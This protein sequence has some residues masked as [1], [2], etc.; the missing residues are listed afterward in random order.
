MT[1]LCIYT[2]MHIKIVIKGKVAIVGEWGDM[3]G[4]R[5]TREGK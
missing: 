4:W 2:Y 1:Y 3:K 5:E